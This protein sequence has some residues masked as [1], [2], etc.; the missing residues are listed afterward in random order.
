VKIG[1]PGFGYE[2]FDHFTREVAEQ[3]FFTANLG[4]NIQTIA[5]RRL[6]QRLG[7]PASRVIEVNRDTLAQYDGEPV[8]LILNGAFMRW[9]FP[10]PAQVKPVFLGFSQRDEH[11]ASLVVTSLHHAAARCLAMGIPVVL[12]RE[13]AD[14][15][16][17]F[18]RRLLRPHLGP[19]FDTINWHPA[20]VDLTAV[21][22]EQTR[23]L[24]ERLAALH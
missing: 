21:R 6:L 8:A 1:V 13:R 23:W 19:D 9:S 17:S 5:L 24:A 18:L 4:D 15:R 2:H 14:S 22:A 3:G 11:T 20:P 12:C 16:F 7:V 10:T